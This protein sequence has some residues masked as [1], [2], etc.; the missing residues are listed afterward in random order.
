MHLVAWFNSVAAM[1]S[2]IPGRP[3]N[4]RL[5]ITFGLLLQTS[6]LCAESSAPAAGTYGAFLEEA[7][8]T[9]IKVAAI[10][11]DAEGHYDL[12][13]E[14]QPFTDHFLSMRPFKCLEGPDKHWCHVPYPYEI[15]RHVSGADLTDLEYDFLFLWKGATD[16]GINMWNGVYY[17]LSVE[18]GR[19]VGHLHE[20]DMDI[21]S[22]P[23]EAG[24]LRP[25]GAY[26]LEEG[27]P[28]S[29]WLPRLV[30]E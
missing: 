10:S 13:M 14:S 27:D 30:I 23:P 20:M 2:A 1:T 29:F 6:A 4:M 21:L 5:A 24:D 26:D 22:A 9:R 18:E 19:L 3:E 11:V 28:D 8:G 16:Y 17:K 25:V 7:G 12:V 15:R